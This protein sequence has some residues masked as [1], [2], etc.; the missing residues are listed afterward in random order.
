MKPIIAFTLFLLAF[1]SF[2]AQAQQSKISQN[3]AKKIAA[4]INHSLDKLNTSIDSVNWN[5]LS[6]LLSKTIETVDKNADAL[7]EI[8]THIDLKKVDANIEKMATKIG[9]SVDAKKLEKQLN[10]LGSNIE[11]AAPSPKK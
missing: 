5:A 2:S 10:E 6:I 8:A 3:E 9:T 4:E 7:T 1:S 11:K